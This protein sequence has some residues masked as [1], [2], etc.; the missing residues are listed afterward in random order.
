MSQVFKGL[1]WSREINIKRYL[2]PETLPEALELLAEYDGNA[3]VIAGGT[4]V[5]PQ[6]RHGNLHVETLI[7]ISRLPNINTISQEADTIVLGG[8]V[9]H[10]QVV[11]SSLIKEKAAAF[12]EASASVGSPQIRNIA[13]IGGNL[14]N[15][16]PA[17]DTAM[18]LLAF[19]ASVT[20]ASQSGDREVPLTEF[21]HGVGKTALNPRREILTQIR[22][23]IP[24]E[25]QGN[26]FLR[27]SK[28][29]SLTIAVLIFSAVVEADKNENVI[30]EARIALGPVAAVPLRASKTEEI[31]RGAPI[32]VET[33]ERAAE[34]VCG[35]SN[36]LSDPVWG[37]A[38][39][40]EEMIKT[41]TKRGLTRA[42]QQIDISLN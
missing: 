28:R 10:T 19:D 36:P 30:K 21:F 20:I 1:H 8:L 25:N 35:E 32:S 3:Q 40:K 16:H 6:L 31:L 41:F 17:A 22:F 12:S 27:L 2:M 26:S 34:S 15:G 18:P 7:D 14:A 23:A 9:T 29:G 38:A 37:S 39:Y 4:D 13:T 11:Q 42:L 33:I 24:K 5:I